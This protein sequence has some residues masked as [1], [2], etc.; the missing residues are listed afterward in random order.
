MDEEQN[1]GLSEAVRL[2][3]ASEVASVAGNY[4]PRFPANPADRKTA[5]F[6]QAALQ[7]LGHEVSI[8]EAAAFWQN[9][10]SCLQ[11]DWSD[12]VYTVPGAVECILEYCEYVA[13]ADNG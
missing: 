8:G 2:T 11:P 1:T 13:A 6:V 7:K 9:Y 4:S 3:L 10:V 5:G 12:D